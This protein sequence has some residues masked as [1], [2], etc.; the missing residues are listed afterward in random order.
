MQEER[1]APGLGIEVNPAG[2]HSSQ[3][4]KHSDQQQHSL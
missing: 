4:Y 3:Q 1:K 2:Q